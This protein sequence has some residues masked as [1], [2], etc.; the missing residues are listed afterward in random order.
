MLKRESLIPLYQQIAENIQKQIEEG[1]YKEGSKIPTEQEL[2]EQFKVSRTTVRLAVGDMLEKGLIEKKQGKG[3]FVRKMPIFNAEQGFRGMYETLV[4]AGMSPETKLVKFQMEE[5]NEATQ[6]ALQ[7]QEG[8][9]VKTI[10]RLCFV[11]G[12]PVVLA[13]IHLHPDVSDLV[14]FEE[15]RHQPIHIILE[16]KMDTPVRQAHFEIFAENAQEEIAKA[17]CLGEK[18]A[19]LGAERILYTQEGLPVE[20]SLL[21]F[22]AEGYRFGLSLANEHQLQLDLSWR[23]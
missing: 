10:Y 5:A 11:E 6:K 21:W 18:E 9:L 2:M 16:Q 23:G 15:A 17:L 20:H 8:E 3:T 13:R 12:K 1:I 22:N 19:V 4:A 7:L 14:S